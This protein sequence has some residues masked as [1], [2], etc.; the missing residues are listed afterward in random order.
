M[1][2]KF[3]HRKD[4]YKEKMIDLSSGR[5][6]LR[7]IHEEI[8]EVQE[9]TEGV[10][11]GPQESVPLENHIMSSPVNHNAPQENRPVSPVE[12]GDEFLEIRPVSPE[13]EG[14]GLLKVRAERAPD[15]EA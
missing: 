2:R 9:V 13:D 1:R 4:Y 10:S 15:G 5:N 6:G 8:D 14:S 11:P 7:T 12:E 3:T